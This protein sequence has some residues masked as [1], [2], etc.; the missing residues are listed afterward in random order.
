MIDECLMTEFRI[1]GDDC[2]L[3]DATRRVAIHSQLCGGHGH[4]STPHCSR[5]TAVAMMSRLLTTGPACFNGT[6]RVRHRV[7]SASNPT[8][9]ASPGHGVN[10]SG[11]ARGGAPVVATVSRTSRYAYQQ[12][13]GTLIPSTRHRLKRWLSG[14]VTAGRVQT[15]LRSCSRR[16]LQLNKVWSSLSTTSS[17]TAS[18][19]AHS[20]ILRRQTSSTTTFVLTDSQRSDRSQKPH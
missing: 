5:L 8:A 11:L 12:P 18:A 3:A 10:S 17:A 2:P 4:R 9:Q 7:A 13:P 1:E 14:S 16:R 15:H 19:I 20:G 6:L